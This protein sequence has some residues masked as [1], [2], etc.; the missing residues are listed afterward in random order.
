[1]PRR[2]ALKKGMKRVG[3]GSLAVAIFAVTLG[4][5]PVPAPIPTPN[6]PV[7]A[8]ARDGFHD[9]DFEFGTWRTHYRLLKRR[10]IGDR[11]WYDCYGTSIV[12]PFWK[13]GG[14]LE[15]GDLKCPNRYIGGMTVR[16]YNQRTHQWT[17]W[18]ATRKLGIAPPPQIGHFD[19]SGVGRFYA[20]DTWNGRPIVNRFQWTRLNDSP[21]FEQ[22]YS[23]D[24]GTTWETNWT[25]D[26]ER[27]PS[28]EN[29][30][31][32]A[33]DR[34]ADGHHGFDFLFGS[35]TTHSTNECEGTSIV[36]PF[37]GGAANL[38]ESNRRC[39]S[40]DV[41]GVTLRL[42]DVSTRRWMLYTARQTSGLVAGLPHVGRFNANGD[43]D[44]F[45]ADAFEGKP[46]IVRDRWLPRNGNPRFE[47]ALSHDGGTTWQTESTTD[48]ERLAKMASWPAKMRACVARSTFVDQ[49][50]RSNVPPSTIPSLRGNM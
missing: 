50:P 24:G 1:M 15:D 17:L 45:A 31:W 2:Q 29:G 43:G 19:A 10:L 42:Y 40:E 5:A 12:R 48:Y 11:E 3:Y 16:F 34:A 27:V 13:G 37:W 35:W 39:P 44:F 49:L 28:S 46:V 9:F 26:Y 38:E 36:R 33:V 8:T 20:Y 47:E 41:R 7:A 6:Y 4:A 14:N 18:W 30:V 32:N 25:T 21:H 23:T 22:A